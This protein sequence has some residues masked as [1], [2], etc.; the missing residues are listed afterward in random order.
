[1]D[2]IT[3]SQ[4]YWISP[5]AL[6]IEPNALGN[7]D[8]LQASCVSG[9]QILVYVKGIKGLDYDAGHNYR[10]WP[11]VAAPTVFN[12]HEAKYV[13][14]AIPRPA[15]AGVPTPSAANAL[16]VFPSEKID[17]YG[18]NAAGTKIGSDLYYYIFLGG[19]LTSSG[20]NGTTPRDWLRDADG[21][22]TIATGYLSS[23]EA[24]ASPTESEWYK[25]SSVSQEVTFLKNIIMKAGTWFLQL[26]AKIIVISS[27]GS[28]RFGE[29]ETAPTITGVADGDTS[30]TSAEHIATP[31]YVDHAALSKLHPDS[32]PFA[33]EVGSLSSKGNLDVFGNTIL[34]K[35]L[36]VGTYNKGISGGNVD[37]YGNAELES[38]ALRSS[39]HVP[40]INYNRTTI[41]VG[42]KWQTVGAGIIQS[43]TPYDAHHGRIKL[44]LEDGEL[45]AI[46]LN[47]ICQGVYHFLDKPNDTE[48]TDTH[49]GNFHFAGFTT[50][51]FKVTNILTADNS[52]FEYEL[53]AAT[54]TTWSDASHPQPFMHFAAY[55][56]PT[57]ADRQSSRLTT[58]TYQIHLAGMTSWTYDQSNI[59]LIIGW[60]DGFTLRQHV[61]DK[62]SKTYKETDKPLHGEGIA[63]GNIYMWGNI[64]QFDRAP[65]V[66][67]QQL[68]Y[69]STTVPDNS[70]SGIE[71]S[72]DHQHINYNGWL[73]TPIT[74]S[75]TDRY[76]WQ[77]WLYTYSDGTYDVSKVSLFAADTTTLTVRTDKSLISVAI[78]DFY[79]T[80]NP[81]DITFDVTARIL[82]GETPLTITAAEASLTGG[83]PTPSPASLP[84]REGQGGSLSYTTEISA[85]SKS[86]LYHITLNGYL[87]TSIDGATPEDTFLTLTLT[88]DLGTATSTLTIAQ[89]REGEDGIDGQDGK[90]GAKG[91]KG[92][93]GTGIE[94]KGTALKYYDRY[95][96]YYAEEN[97]QS[98]IYLVYG[99]IIYNPHP[100][101]IG[102][103]FIYTYDADTDTTDITE[104]DLGDTYY[105]EENGHLF[106]ASLMDEYRAVTAWTDC[107]NIKGQD[108]VLY[109]LDIPNT[110]LEHL[111]TF[112]ITVVKTAG[113]DTA[114]I[115][116]DQ[117][118]TEGVAVIG[119]AVEW[120]AQNQRFHLPNGAVKGTTYTITLML[121]GYVINTYS[122]QC[123]GN[124]DRGYVGVTVR[125]SEWQPGVYYRNDSDDGSADN[126][127][128]RY[129][130]EVSITNLA[131][132]KAEWFLAT[133]DHN[134]HLSTDTNKPISAGN[135]YW[136]KIND[137]RPLRTPFADIT[138]ALIDYLQVKQ[139]LIKDKNNHIYGAFGNQDDVDYPLW[140][141]GEDW[142]HAIV[143]FD[144]NGNVQF[145]NPDSGSYFTVK[146]GNVSMQG[147]I[148]ATGGTFLGEVNFGGEQN[149]NIA[150][151][152]DHDSQGAAIVVY[153][154]PDEQMHVG[155]GKNEQG[156]DTCGIFFPDAFF[157]NSGINITAQN[158]YDTLRAF[159]GRY[160]AWTGEAYPL[161]R[162]GHSDTL[163]GQ[164]EITYNANGTLRVLMQ[165]LPTTKPIEKNLLYNDNGTLKIS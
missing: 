160:T 62:E 53:R 152:P 133:R 67:A 76:V 43:V 75:P 110:I 135:D 96:D 23:D 98:G 15:T 119:E 124:G 34:H 4:D 30:P 36:T 19:I 150:F 147:N 99:K 148:K 32:T 94:I 1:M 158:G 41:T 143:R 97:K 29:S 136:T 8:Y 84:L 3:T 123:I 122:I 162:L 149:T 140:F 153:Q 100:V 161:F 52:E 21:L 39:L 55:A 134:N 17:I 38:L 47:D 120:N 44:Q 86:V 6:Y 72:S 37:F 24:L 111:T 57:N 68:Y 59:R 87:S 20:D 106:V 7:P 50:I 108:A 101:S 93:A 80:S 54:D 51:F 63:V 154:G 69:Q 126:D 14:A 90:P 138:T 165:N 61:W 79:D 92:D 26:F 56:N 83:V 102:G 163:K 11:L 107:G 2:Y 81:D 70:P 58:Q 113:P 66:I 35:G 74:P 60:L 109:T 71:I 142:Q 78:S 118:T 95:G 131:T 116:Y 82:S 132:G 127:G 49:D 130:D 9:A 89:N 141:G 25:Y 103:A 27:G 22:H 164:C 128:N 157:T 85:D 45:G 88:S 137:L 42:N 77:Q 91:D 40:E 146:D 65:S 117:A 12:T 64:D 16:I 121:N 73:S 104:A 129:L 48:T 112:P 31:A 28:I 139:L 156:F 18:T 105:V 151:D 5:N 33:L 46:A 114:P 115:S 13:Y 10:R 155:N 125:R 144:K 145:G 159:L